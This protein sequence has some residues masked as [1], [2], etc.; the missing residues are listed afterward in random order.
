MSNIKIDICAEYLR[1]GTFNRYYLEVH[2]KE[3]EWGFGSGRC[4]TAEEIADSVL[5]SVIEYGDDNPVYN[6]SL[7]SGSHPLEKCRKNCPHWYYTQRPDDNLV[8]KL[9]GYLSDQEL[10]E[11][12]RKSIEN[13]SCNCNEGN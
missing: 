11:E 1:D 6:I 9:E 4:K 2:S 7:S 12:I 8:G 10:I 3:G 13:S 5:E